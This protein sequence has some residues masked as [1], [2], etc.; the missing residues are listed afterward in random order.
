MNRLDLLNKFGRYFKREAKDLIGKIKADGFNIRKERGIE[1]FDMPVEV[2]LSKYDKNTQQFLKK[3][4]GLSPQEQKCLTYF[5]QG[6]SAQ[7]TAAVMGISQRTVESY[8]E[9]IKSKLGCISK[10]D[11]LDY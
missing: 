8:F 10:Y 1:S 6:K 3:V 4:S 2:A 5:Q 9:M 7:D 11:L